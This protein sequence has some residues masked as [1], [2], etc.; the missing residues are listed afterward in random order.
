VEVTALGIDPEVLQR[1]YAT[2]DEG[3][4]P[5][6]YEEFLQAATEVRVRCTQRRRAAAA[7]GGGARPPNFARA[8]GAATAGWLP[9]TRWA[10]RGCRLRS[11]TKKERGTWTR[12][13]RAPRRT[14]QPKGAPHGC[15]V[16]PVHWRCLLGM[17]VLA[18]LRGEVAGGAVKP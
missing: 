5:W 2:P 14:C 1:F 13:G 4:A 7:E 6:A 18:E 10:R 16:V 3:E 8:Q 15:A 11:R 12:A 9:L 17:R